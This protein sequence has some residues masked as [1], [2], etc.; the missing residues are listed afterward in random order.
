MGILMDSKKVA[1]IGIIGGSGMYSMLSTV[2]EIQIETRYG[3]PSDKVVISEYGGKRIAFTPR[4][5]RKHTIPPHRVP[6]MA[7]MQAMKELGVSRVIS[8][9]A[10]GS[11]RKDYKPGEFVIFDQFVNMAQG[12]ADT[13]FDSERVV[14]V[15]MA[16]PYC[17][18][19]RRVCAEAL[20]GRGAEYHE[21]CTVLVINGPRF[22]TKAESR[23]FSSNHMDVINMTQYP[24]AALAREHGICYLGVGVITD[25]DA[26]IAEDDAPPAAFDMINK[27]FDQNSETLKSA[28]TD[29]LPKISDTKGCSC[30]ASLNGA[31]ATKTE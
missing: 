11:L 5:G 18:E 27:I 3:R 29:M 17:P 15:S 16:D 19:L 14:H 25:Y 28:I 21:S 23:F 13:I 24:E 20:K 2:D 10:V 8:T 4:H 7:N 30:S 1:D 12:R 6:Y 31:Q 22:S 26:G 9:N